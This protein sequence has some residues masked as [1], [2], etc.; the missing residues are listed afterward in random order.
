M[1]KENTPVS[2]LYGAGVMCYNAYKKSMGRYAMSELGANK[3]RNSSIELLR[4]IC[5]FGI[6]SMHTFRDFASSCTGINLIY[7]TF[8]N[9]VFNMGVTI[10]M[11]ITGYFGAKPSAKKIISLEMMIWFYSFAGLMISSICYSG[12]SIIEF[13]KACLPISTKKYWYM[14][15]YM[16][17]ICLSGY[18]NKITEKLCKKDMQ[19]LLA[20]LIAFFY[21]M[22]TFTY[23]QIMEDSGKGL[24]NMLTVYL[25]GRYVHK[26]HDEIRSAMKTLIV[27]FAAIF[28]IFTVNLTASYVTVN[29]VGI[30]SPWARD[31]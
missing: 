22:P 24:A 12:F 27:A 5:I 28:I 7:G 9:S 4:I 13:F 8:I 16:V 6:I 19:V 10:F 2:Y 3:T 14:S 18:L 15:V 11:L 20:I 21:I 23:F 25:L 17:I 30:R 31:N 1:V 26:Y 29:G